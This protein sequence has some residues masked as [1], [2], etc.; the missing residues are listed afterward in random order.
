MIHGKS[1]G[2]GFRRQ[3]F[4]IFFLSYL[5]LKLL[6]IPQPCCLAMCPKVST[7][8][9]RWEFGTF[10][11][12]LRKWFAALQ[13]QHKTD[14]SLRENQEQSASSTCLLYS[15]EFM[16]THEGLNIHCIEPFPENM[17]YILDPWS[18]SA[19]RAHSFLSKPI[20]KKPFVFHSQDSGY[21]THLGTCDGA[22]QVWESLKEKTQGTCKA[23]EIPEL[24][25]N[26]VFFQQH[27]FG[28][29]QYIVSKACWKCLNPFIGS[30]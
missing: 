4:N 15:H 11:E 18:L 30:W 10:E 13:T 8:S 29:T 26:W 19:V 2:L 21:S 22:T 1:K 9:P 25:S 28:F 24:S 12:A 27:H 7:E 20:Q 14:W 3:I 5:L 6:R 17:N 23:H 16:K